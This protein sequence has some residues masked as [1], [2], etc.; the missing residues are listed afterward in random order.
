MPKLDRAET[1]QVPREPTAEMVEAA[2][3]E[4]TR[5]GSRGIPDI[6]RAMLAAA[7]QVEG[8]IAVPKE[9][10]ELSEKAGLDVGEWQLGLVGNFNLIAYNGED[11][12]ALG[13][14]PHGE[15]ARFIALLVNWFR[16]N[17]P[18]LLEL[19]QTMKDQECPLCKGT[20]KRQVP[21]FVDPNK[22]IENSCNVCRGSGRI[23]AAIDAKL[24]EGK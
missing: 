21:S 20:G 15:R 13:L 16:A 1:V 5:E 7:P 17:Y 14:I 4:W 12:T 8:W 10:R 6:Y 19:T 24:E 9:L 22:T 11:A 3:E 23:D 18:S 2:I